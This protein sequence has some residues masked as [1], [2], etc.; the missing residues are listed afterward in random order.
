MKISLALPFHNEKENL[1]ILL[2]LIEKNLLKIDKYSYEVNLVDDL[3]NDESF[4]E[5]KKFINST[6][7]K[8]IFNLFRLEKKGFQS[9]ALKKGFYESTGDYIICMD[10]DLQDDPEYLPNFIEKIS[11]NFEIVIGLRK[12]RKAPSILRSGLKVYDYIFEK[13]FKKNLTTYRAQFAAYKS[14]YVKNL[15]W[16]KNDHRYLIPVAINRGANLI[17]E[18]DIIFKE[19]K[20]GRSHYNRY[21]KV[22]WGVIELGIFLFRLRSGKYN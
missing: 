8:V 12:N 6:K 21:L 15:P 10:T 22:F 2:P 5:C 4:E 14:N 19:R 16:Y 13:I 17:S 7:S 20:I 1:K 11:N 18:I 3:S 9:G